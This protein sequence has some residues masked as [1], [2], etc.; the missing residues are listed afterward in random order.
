MDGVDLS[1]ILIKVSIN[2]LLLEFSRI[3]KNKNTKR[4]FKP[5]HGVGENNE[6]RHWLVRK[7]RKPV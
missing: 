7:F 3:S 2:R 4:D 6:N 5:Q 1:K